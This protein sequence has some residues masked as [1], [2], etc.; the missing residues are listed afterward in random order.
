[1]IWKLLKTTYLN[2]TVHQSCLVLGSLEVR[3][4]NGILDSLPPPCNKGSKGLGVCRPHRLATHKVQACLLPW[5]TWSAIT[6]QPH[7]LTIKR[8]LLHKVTRFP[9]ASLR[10]LTFHCSPVVGA[11]ASVCPSVVLG[12][13]SKVSLIVSCGRSSHDNDFWQCR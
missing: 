10:D 9:A 1:M 2:T 5:S 4:R 6:F 13:V 3:G 7:L 11:E 12:V 8:K